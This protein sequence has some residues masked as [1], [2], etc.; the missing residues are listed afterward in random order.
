MTRG[1][2]LVAVML[3]A[4]VAGCDD[5]P[6]TASRVVTGELAGR[7]EAEL[8]V[9]SGADT[10]TVRAADLGDDLFRASAPVGARVVPVADVDRSAVRVSLTDSAGP[11]GADLVVELNTKVRW[12][13]RLDGGAKQAT[14]AMGGSRLAGLDFGAGNSRIEASLP[15][16]TGTVPVRMAGGASVFDLRLPRDVATQV[17]IAGGAGS[18]TIDGVQHTGIPGG[19][20]YTPDGWD[21]ATD[22]YLIDNTA[23]VSSLT[24]DRIPG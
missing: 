13:I 12:R 3:L 6:G 21:S 24:V 16:P 19:T 11:G 4:V 14:V 5:D 1:A 22:R 7:H 10:V 9:V 17:R 23:G 2:A 15:E 20:V 8:D 18:A